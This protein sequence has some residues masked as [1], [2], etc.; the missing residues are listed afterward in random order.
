MS[1]SFN[2]DAFKSTLK[3]LFQDHSPAIPHFAVEDIRELSPAKLKEQG[4]KGVIFDKDNTITAPYKNEIFETLREVVQ[5]FKDTFGENMMILSNSA[6]TKDDK[7]Y[8][9]AIEI[10]TKLNIPVIRH[11]R[12]KPEGVESVEQSFSCPLE[13]IVMIGDRLLTDTLFGN[14]SGMLTIHTGILTTKGDNKPAALA[15]I[16]ENSL[17]RGWK[18]RGG[19]AP[20]HSLQSIVL[21]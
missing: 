10:E 2:S 15:R 7:N 5:E 20:V 16:W 19:V 21:K 11:D 14:R 4:I 3:I 9:D 18:K 8:A 17:L 1:Q 12:K 6:G 13:S